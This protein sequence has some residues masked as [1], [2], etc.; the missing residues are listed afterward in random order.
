[1]FGV[2]AVDVLDGEFADI[3]F[4]HSWHLQRSMTWSMTWSMTF[5]LCSEACNTSQLFCLPVA[6]HRRPWKLQSCLV[7]VHVAWVPVRWAQ[8]RSP[9]FDGRSHWPCWAV[10]PAHL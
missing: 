9:W 5:P 2:Y 8:G 6:F 3:S 1:M 4:R 7:L 10:M